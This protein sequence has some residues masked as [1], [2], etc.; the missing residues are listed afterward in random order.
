MSDLLVLC[1]HGISADWPDDT[2][3]TPE[4]FAAQ[5]ESLVARG[6]RG[7]TLTE[8]LTAPRH[9]KTLVVTF[10]DAATSVD[11]HARPVLDRL[12]LPGTVFVPTDLP[13][14]GRPMAW[15]G[16]AQWLGGPHEHELA[17]IGWDRLRELAAA[18]WEIGSHSRSHP[19]LTTLGDQRLRDE[20]VGSKAELERRLEAPCHSIAYPYSDVDA[21][22]ARAARDAGYGV[23]V[24][25]PLEPTPSL[26]L[27][28][29]RVGVY[30]GDT[31]RRV[32]LRARRRAYGLSPTGRAV[33]AALAGG[34][35]LVRR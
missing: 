35:R 13:D 30:R 26:P 5:V 10:D 19:R 34:L 29:S 31:A 18:G 11:E 22:V 24:T 23:G 16:L 14:G 15:D 4:A 25:V 7:A 3:V 21:R 27:L 8:A 12:G 28:W 2:A 32:W 6:Y 9:P 20:L 33:D 1:Y 17:C